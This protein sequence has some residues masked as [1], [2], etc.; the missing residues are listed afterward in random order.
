MPRDRV[1]PAGDKRPLFVTRFGL[2]DRTAIGVQTKR[3]LGHFSD[4]LHLYWNEG[5]FDPH[6]P[7]S[8]C[9]DNWPFARISALKRKTLISKGLQKLRISRWD[10]ETPSPS[11]R[12]YL[13]GL[14]EDISTVY[15]APIDSADARRMKEIARL[16]NLPFVIHLWDFLDNAG[17]EATHWL[18]GNAKHAFCLNEEILENVKKTQSNSSILPFNRLPSEARA[19]FPLG[20]TTTIAIMGDIGSYVGGIPSLISAINLLRHTGKTY[21]IVY[22][23]NQRSLKR[24]GLNSCNLI[25]ATG[26]ITSS[27]QRDEILSRCAIGFM[28]GPSNSPDYDPRSKYSIPSRIL[29]FMSVG[30]PVVGTVHLDSA[31]FSF[32]RELGIH[33]WLGQNDPVRIAEALMAHTERRIW[34]ASS[35]ASLIA[36]DTFYAAYD[37][38]VLKNALKA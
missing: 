8:L 4:Y 7:N 34:T 31:T 36:F 15:F 25:S 38:G 16:L 5:L 3:L 9:L 18:I 14:R 24:L 10:D 33:A 29:D 26:F 13:S 1:V 19:G 35:D 12:S 22:I 28:P 17:D 23:G 20:K 11:L 32:C 30:I 21:R 37:L 27:A 2:S 6:Y